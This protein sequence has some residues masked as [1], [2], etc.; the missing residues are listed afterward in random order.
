MNKYIVIGCAAAMLAGSNIFAGSA[1]AP[2]ANSS[3]D[4]RLN[5]TVKE[6]TDVV[7]FVRDNADPNV[8][9]KTYLV[10]NVNPYEMRACLRQ[11]VQTRKVNGDNTN[12]DVVTFSDGTNVL[13]ISA[14]DYRFNDTPNAQGFDS[15]VRELDKPKLLSASGRNSFVYSPI[16]R[17]SAEILNMVKQVGANTVSLVMG[18]PGATDSLAEDP[19]LNLV[20]FHIAPFSRHTVMDVLKNY[21]QPYQQ[22]RAKVTVYE[23]YAENDTKLGLD[24]QA[25]KNNEGIDLFSAGGRFSRNH[26]GIDLVSGAK[27]NDTTYFQFNPKWNTKYVDFLTSKG[28]AKVV[29]T[30]EITLRNNTTGV[31]KKTT[32]VFTAKSTP[33]EDASYDAASC[34]YTADNNS[35]VARDFKGRDIILNTNAYGDDQ[36]DTE[37]AA[38]AV[39]YISK[40]GKDSNIRYKLRLDSYSKAGFTI[41]GKA[42]GKQ[43]EAAVIQDAA[44]TALTEYN[45]GHQRGNIINLE[46]SQQFGFTLEMTPSINTLATQLHVKI[47][48]SS[49]IGY[50]SDG[51]PRIQNGAAID[52]DF[53]ISNQGTKL[54]IGGI[55]KRSVM[56]V[57]GGLPI[58]KDLPVIGWIFSTE[59]EA[60]KRSQLLVVAE[61]L[62]DTKA[63]NYK[64]AIQS[65][66]D[67]LTG[68]G[69]SNSYGYR[70]Y[71]LDSDR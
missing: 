5:V 43:I 24:F 23:L 7:H 30:S 13:L 63:D 33:A 67:K 71:L 40:V 21:D 10:K 54:I 38:S 69:E 22:V 65:V 59:T 36:A 31:I 45:A 8:I 11:M 56:R 1:A 57:S 20:F 32:Q 62:P 37:A 70:Q 39:V 6:N 41:N 46:P 60:T 2:Y 9:T 58:L 51:T 27:F 35:V 68:S 66:K 15:I 55:E 14:E 49:L 34:A 25:W 29:H 42:V 19:G 3:V 52:T 50:T 26:N 48:N 47:E 53:T 12:I 18:N 61:V 4:A 17:S 16:Y 44:E 64:K 28:K